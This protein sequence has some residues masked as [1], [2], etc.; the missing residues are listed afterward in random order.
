[1]PAT[2]TA[3]EVGKRLVELCK[4]GQNRKAIEE[5]YADD[6]VSI[7]AMAA[8]PKGRETKGKKDLLAGSDWF[9]EAHEIHAGEID[10]PYPC[11]DKFICFMSIDLTARQ[12]P[13]AGQRM[14]MK[15]ACHYTVKNGKITRSEFYYDPGC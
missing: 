15:E 12:G 9:F 14:Q 4:Q 7:E 2:A 6:A 13:M 1:M 10:G 3:N 5:L 8:G 11:D